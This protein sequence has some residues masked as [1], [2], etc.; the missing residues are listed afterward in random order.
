MIIIIIMAEAAALN[1]QLVAK[2]CSSFENKLNRKRRRTMIVTMATKTTYT[3]KPV[4][5]PLMI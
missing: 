3:N 2:D 4:I 1:V 5:N